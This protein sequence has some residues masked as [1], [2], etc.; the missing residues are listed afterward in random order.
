[1]ETGDLH[2][3]AAVI[4]K[5]D[6]TRRRAR[7]ALRQAADLRLPGAAPATMAE[8]STWTGLSRPK[9]F[10]DVD[11]G[12]FKTSDKARKRGSKVLFPVVEA[13]KYLEQMGVL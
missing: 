7:K 9:I 8:L 10:A 4:A 3:A 12:V 5:A 6:G 1:M 2:D 13:L 11:A